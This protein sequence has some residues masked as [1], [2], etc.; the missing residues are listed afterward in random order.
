MHTFLLIDDHPL[1][2]IGLEG[3]IYNSFGRNSKVF[4]AQNSKVALDLIKE[5]PIDLIVLDLFIPETDTQFLIIQLKLIRPNTKIL[6]QSSGAEEVYAIHYLKQGVNGYISKSATKEDLVGAITTTLNGKNYFSPNTIALMLNQLSNKP[7]TNPFN[8]LSKREL[9]VAKQLTIGKKGNEI[10]QTLN[11]HPS[12][13]S[14]L[15]CRIFKK[16]N[17][18]NQTDFER[19]YRMYDNPEH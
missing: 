1:V 13:I 18:A 19:L 8:L 15:K 9:E 10:A 2:L 14:T 12:T 7:T 6:I 16:F 4:T 17:V 3:L 11:A 5:H